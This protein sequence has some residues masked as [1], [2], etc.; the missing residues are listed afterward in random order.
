LPPTKE[1]L[2]TVYPAADCEHL[3]RHCRLV[4]ILE[5][6]GLVVLEQ[7]DGLPP[8][9]VDQFGQAS[10][11]GN[12]VIQIPIFGADRETFSEELM[13]LF[14]CLSVRNQAQ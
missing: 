8:V 11:R 14:N 5:D 12:E 10:H 2:L 3:G 7:R 9:Q 6:E 4:E 13:D 1:R